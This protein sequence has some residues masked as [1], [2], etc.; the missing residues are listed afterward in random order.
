M[1][2]VPAKWWKSS[3]VMSFLCTIFHLFFLLATKKEE[4]VKFKTQ[5]VFG[6]RDLVGFFS[7][8]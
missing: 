8:L 6:L 3:E 7:I 2:Q 4:L 5:A 1:Q